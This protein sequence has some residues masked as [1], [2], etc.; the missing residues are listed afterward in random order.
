MQQ[1]LYRIISDREAWLTVY[2][3]TLRSLERNIS[4]PAL[5]ADWAEQ[6]ADTAL[7]DLKKRGL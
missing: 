6:V 2:A 1:E 7:A 3:A 5:M 4:T